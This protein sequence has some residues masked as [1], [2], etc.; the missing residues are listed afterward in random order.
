MEGWNSFLGRRKGRQKWKTHRITLRVP[1]LQANFRTT[2]TIEFQLL[3]AKNTRDLRTRTTQ[4]PIGG[5]RN[6]YFNR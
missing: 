5:Y 3:F 4:N 2:C 1:Q 6:S